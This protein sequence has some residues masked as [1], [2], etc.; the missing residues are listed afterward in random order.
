MLAVLRAGA[1]LT[2]IDVSQPDARV[3]DVIKRARPSLLVDTTEQTWDPA[4]GAA[5]VVRL[6]EL[7]QAAAGEI[8]LPAVAAGADAYVCFTSGTTG[9]PRGVLG[10]HGALAHF[11]VWEQEALAMGAGDRVAQMAALT[12]DAVFKDLFPAL[13]AGAT[14]C[15]PPTDRP[16]VDLAQVLAWLREDEV[17][18]LQTVPSVLVPAGRTARGGGLSGTAAD[19]SLRRA[20]A[21]WSREPL[22]SGHGQRGGTVREPL[23]DD[24]G[25]HPQVLVP[26]T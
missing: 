8:G 4:A 15:L 20:A 13:I 24:R 23:R 10:W 17:T 3:H 18:V 2:M 26:G 1:V 19:M 11:C 9:E 7:E 25:N 14:V 5:P 16:F 6:A 22:A 12:F 21:G